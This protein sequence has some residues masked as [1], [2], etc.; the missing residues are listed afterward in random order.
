MVIEFA[1]VFDRLDS[2]ESGGA[3]ERNQQ[4]EPQA[5]DVSLLGG[6]DR[7]RHGEGVSKISTS[8]LAPARGMESALA[9]SEKSLGEPERSTMYVPSIAMKN[10]I[11]L[12]RK[13]QI[14]TLPAVGS[15]WRD[16]RIG[17]MFLGN[18]AVFQ[19]CLGAKICL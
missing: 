2:K 17:G 7:Q 4:I 8:V 13:S 16:D 3:Y 15:P 5:P 1:G 9:C 12:A 14:A 19:D 6:V 11:S 10:M 18:K